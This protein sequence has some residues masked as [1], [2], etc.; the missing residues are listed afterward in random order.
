MSFKTHLL[1][2]TE[3][4]NNTSSMSFNPPTRENKTY[5]FQQMQAGELPT[6]HQL[7]TPSEALPPVALC[8]PAPVGKANLQRVLLTDGLSQMPRGFPCS[9][10]GIFFFFLGWLGLRE[11]F[12]KERERGRNPL[13]DWALVNSGNSSLRNPHG[14]LLQGQPCRENR[15]GRITHLPLNQ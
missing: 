2:P 11:P 5:S 12:P 15:C 13:G 10:K 4:T 3:K 1:K 6:Y 14:L 9:K 8:P 7:P